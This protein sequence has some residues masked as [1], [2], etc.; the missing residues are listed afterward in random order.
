MGFGRLVGRMPK[1]P[2]NQA[3]C[4]CK[5][6][7]QQRLFMFRRCPSIWMHL[8][9]FVPT[10]M[11]ASGS[12]DVRR[13]TCHARHLPQVQKQQRF[14]K[15]GDYRW[16][17]GDLSIGITG[18]LPRW[19]GHGQTGELLNDKDCWHNHDNYYDNMNTCDVDMRVLFIRRAYLSLSLYTVIIARTHTHTQT[20]T[21][22]Y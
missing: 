20:H 1:I 3:M 7:A 13:E 5:A 17:P 18:A 15:K 16:L 10:S 2:P 14:R 4:C 11:C 9:L 12:S 8:A 22:T 21:H 19:P 6:I